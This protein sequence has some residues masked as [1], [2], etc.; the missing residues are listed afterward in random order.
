MNP[1]KRGIGA[2][3]KAGAV[4]VLIIVLLGA[5]YVIPKFSVSS[6]SQASSANSSV[7]QITGMPAL[8][9]GFTRMEVS[10][11]ASDTTDG[12]L[13]N[14]SY[15]YAVLGRGTLNSTEYTRVEY[16]TVGAGNSVVV[17]YNSTGGIGE[18][19]VVGVRN[20]TGNGAG[21]LPF[22]TIYG[23]AF[24]TLASITSNSTLLSLLSK[25][26]EGLTSIGPTQM[27]VT[28]YVLSGRSYPYS[29][30]TLKIVTI[31]GT[32]AKLATY[33]DEKTAD[34]SISILQVTSLTR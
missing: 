6:Q 21:N 26:S 12:V 23:N 19:D 24:G 29:S 5:I 32:N 9:Y 17:W 2:A 30:L 31:P 28:T 27:Y 8:F 20:Y 22:I 34:G 14:Q 7:K 10:V 15:S 3:G 33:L 4:V 25:T 13:Q 18:V 16:T 11:Y 1:S